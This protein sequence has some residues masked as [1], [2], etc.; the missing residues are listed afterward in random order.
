M[1]GR[2]DRVKGAKRREKRE[3]RVL[4]KSTS[5]K[6]CTKTRT[7]KPIFIFGCLGGPGSFADGDRIRLQTT[8][9]FF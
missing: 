5:K 9:A 8:K 6:G 1:L 2:V 3:E 4:V 7:L